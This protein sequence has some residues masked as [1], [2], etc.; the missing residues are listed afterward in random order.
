MVFGVMGAVSAATRKKAW[1]GAL[2]RVFR[3]V[4]VAW[5]RG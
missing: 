1:H 3:P 5:G 2:G 4:A